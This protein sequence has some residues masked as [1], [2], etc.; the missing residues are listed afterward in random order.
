[1]VN[2][3]ELCAGAAAGGPVGPMF[4][5]LREGVEKSFAF[6]ST[7]KSVKSTV[8]S[9]A[10]LILQIEGHNTTL[11]GTRAAE[12]EPLKKTTEEGAK[13]ILE[14]LEVNEWSCL[15][16]HYTDQLVELDESLKRYLEILQVQGVIDVKENLVLTKENTRLAEKNIG[17]VSTLNQTVQVGLTDIQ[18]GQDVMTKGMDAV[19]HELKKL[20]YY[21]GYENKVGS[22]NEAAGLEAAV[23]ELDEELDTSCNSGSVWR[24]RLRQKIN[25]CFQ[26]SAK[27]FVLNRE[28]SYIRTEELHS[29]RVQI[30]EGVNLVRNWSKVLEWTDDLES[31]YSD[32]FLHLEDTLDRLYYRLK[33]IQPFRWNTGKCSCRTMSTKDSVTIKECS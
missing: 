33:A 3:W 16:G 25:R 12:V 14:L 27:K 21:N 20:K 30:E 24:S 10:P 5:L 17:L 4:D 26:V 15:K 11:G 8:D 31:A 13:L 29:F 6:N 23:H 9:L 19:L 28:I 18:K 7:L 22:L 1:M 32:K 2:A